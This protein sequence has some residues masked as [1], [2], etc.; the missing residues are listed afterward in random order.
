MNRTW[1]LPG[2]LAAALAAG[3][4]ADPTQ[5]YT[6]ASQFR[7]DVQTV[8]VPIFR[9]EAGEFR[10]NI[11]I[12]LTEAIIKHIEAQTPYKV[13]DRSRADTLLE[14]TLRWARIRPLSFDPRTGMAREVQVRLCVD[15]IWKDLREPGKVFA[16]RKNFRVAADYIPQCP[17]SEDF[18]LGSED[19]INKLGQRI[20]EQLAQP[21]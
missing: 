8:A 18:F 9:R 7:T 2:I 13:V 12:R 16:E 21:W 4:N 15:F 11:E 5:G 17:F 10:R 19:A 14:G 1:I 3:C 20:V 6:T